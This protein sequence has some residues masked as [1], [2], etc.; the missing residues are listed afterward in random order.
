[1]VTNASLVL[2][3]DSYP[4]S[5]ALAT[6]FNL[7]CCVVKG[8]DICGLRLPANQLLIPKLV[9]LDICEASEL[10][11]LDLMEELRGFYMLIFI[12]AFA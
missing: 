11:R 3:E 7:C 10:M 6:I 12:V 4:T 1:V 8:V 2:P 9:W 5:I